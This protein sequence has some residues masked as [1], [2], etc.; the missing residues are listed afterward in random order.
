MSPDK[1]F[2]ASVLR[3]KPYMA[4]IAV[5]TAAA[6][7]MTQMPLVDD[8]GFEFAFFTAAIATFAT[9][10]M[11]VHLVNGWRRDGLRTD[12]TRNTHHSALLALLFGLSLSTLLLPMVVMFVKS[13]IS[14]FCNVPEGLAFYL[15]LPGI[16]VLWA[17]A[18]ALVCALSAERRRHATLLFL[19]VMFVSVGISLFRLATNPPVFAYNPIIGYFPGPIYDEVVVITSTLLAA[20]A[21]VLVSV[22]AMVAGLCAC[23]DPSARKIRPSLLWKIRGGSP[24]GGSA[25]GSAATGMTMRILFLVSV[26]VLAVAYVYRAP[27]GI[28]IDRAHIQQTLG[29]HRQTA[30]FDIFYD[31]NSI[32]AWNI[33]L[34]ARD[35]EYQLDR[36]ITYLDVP[37]PRARIASYIYGSADQKKRL[38]GARHTSIERPGAD[39]MHLNNASF[40]HPVLRHEL[41]H[42]MSAAFGN[43]LFGGS[44]WIGFHEGLA[45][46]VDWQDTPMNPHEWS[47]AMRELGLAPS[48]ENLLSMTGFWTAASSRSYTLCGSFV[49]FLI[50]RYGL[51]A[52]KQAFPDGAVEASYGRS[53][54]E[55]IAEW[56][57]FVDGIT[58]RE[59]QLRIARQRFIRPAIFSR[60]CPHEVAALNDRAWQAYNGQRYG[61]AVRDFD[62]V[63]ALESENPSALRGLLYGIYRQG[64][65]E[66]IESVAQRIERPD[67]TVG[68]LADTQLVRGDTAWKTGRMDDARRSYEAVVGLQASEAMSRAASIRL[69]VL[70]REPIRDTIMTYLTAVTGHWRLVL[71]VR[72]AGD[73]APDYG[74][75]H[76][77]LGRWLFL[78]GSYEEALTYLAKADV[79]G[80]PDD[81]VRQESLRLEAMAHFYLERYDQSAEAFGRMAALVGSGG[82]ARTAEAWIDRCRWYQ[83]NGSDGPA[84]QANRAR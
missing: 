83:Q 6:A 18:V 79:I 65:Y 71:S 76:Y 14:G 11:T 1:H 45:E 39:E 24:S 59:D 72:D 53:P 35:H 56:E 54:A 42:V 31:S 36:V 40:P 2:I 60:H 64:D 5:L 69:E 9:G 10:V 29:G 13:W 21:I 58:L 8:L 41:V 38:M 27:L 7:A 63:L 55:L 30:H 26:V 4:A 19:G 49:R 16:S 75:G 52:F 33:D 67:Q 77:L 51:P 17:T 20:R 68:L 66:R 15:L 25:G 32:S 50:E 81:V 44:Y 61:D 37:A 78:S 73:L 74:T 57:T 12:G 34:I 84:S 23:F 82:V 46:A 80:L 43:A 22:L 70:D 48:L 28:V 3:R 47:R 62:R